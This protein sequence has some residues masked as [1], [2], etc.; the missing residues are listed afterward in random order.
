MRGLVVG[1]RILHLPLS[2]PRGSGGAL[3]SPPPPN[4]RRRNG[5]AAACASSASS[6][7]EKGTG[8]VEKEE[9]E[10]D[11]EVKTH[12]AAVTALLALNNNNNNKAVHVVSA[13]LDKT[14][15]L[16]RFPLLPTSSRKVTQHLTYPPSDT[17]RV[18]LPSL[19][20]ACVPPAFSLA[21]MPAAGLIFAGLYGREVVAWS[22]DDVTASLSPL[23]GVRLGGHTGWVRALAVVD[24]WLFSAACNYVRVWR[25][26]ERSRPDTSILEMKRSLTQSLNVMNTAHDGR[27]ATMAYCQSAGVV[28]TAGFDGAIRVWSKE[29]LELLSESQCGHGGDVVYTLAAAEPL[30]LVSGGGDKVQD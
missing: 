15:R 18:D 7:R 19:S 2:T 23:E 10:D 22:H 25:F 8:E 1:V 6:S 26:D 14:L 21:W 27:I 28:C 17:T 4:G 20:P 11:I 24:K 29:L 12:A 9:K 3:G 16:C 30:M 13:S 5:G